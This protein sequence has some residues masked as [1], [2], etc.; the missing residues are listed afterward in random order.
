MKNLIIRPLTPDDRTEM[1]D[2]L[3][4]RDGADMSSAEQRWT[5]LSWMAFHNPVAD[6]EPT[7]YVAVYKDHIV[8]HLGRMPALFAYKG[9]E[10]R[11]YFI[12][13]LFVH[14]SKRKQGLGFFVSIALYDRANKDSN[15]FCCLVW[16]TPL[17]LELQR[18]SG[19]LETSATGLVRPLNGNDFL[20]HPIA[21]RILNPMVSGLSR[22]TG[23]ILEGFGGNGT[24]TRTVARCDSQ[25]DILWN[26]LRPRLNLCSSKSAAILNWKYVDRP[27]ARET[28]IV[29]ERAGALTGFIAL[30][31]SPEKREEKV[32]IVVDILADPDDKHTVA[33]LCQAAVRHFHNLRLGS[34]RAVMSDP[35]FA[36]IFRRHFFLATANAR[37][38]VMFG[39]VDRSPVPGDV[40]TDTNQW[41]FTRGESDGYMLST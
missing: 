36:S 3:A 40:L 21:R 35:R 14:P 20:K 29:A 7:Y 38:V 18:K 33:A 25:F 11:G 41:N 2:L 4:T 37:R 12:H 6:G 39:N 13:D 23:S 34:A 16:T 5:M 26:S 9:T 24:T 28:I 1:I 32:G 15:S 10:H 8:A 22:M 31:T 27:F 19:Y 30:T 17:N